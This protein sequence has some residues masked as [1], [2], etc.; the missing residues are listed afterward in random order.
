MK[1]GNIGIR[2]LADIGIADIDV[3]GTNRRKKNVFDF[4]GTVHF[5]RSKP[6]TK[7]K[8]GS[9][10]PDYS[11][12]F[13]FDLYNIEH[14]PKGS[15]IYYLDQE[16]KFIK[17]KEY[18]GYVSSYLNIWPPK[19]DKEKSNV[20][21][22]VK[23]SDGSKV[24]ELLEYECKEWNKD[25]KTF[26]IP[27]TKIEI[28]KMNTENSD[29][30]NYYKINIQC[31]E[32]FENDIS[33]NTKYNENIVGRIIVKANAKIYETTIQPVLVSF[34][35]TASTSIEIKDHETFV[36]GLVNYFN[37]KSFN[38]AY[39]RGKLADK[40]HAVTF[41][42]S[43]FLK[44]DVVKL[45]NKNLFVNYTESNQIN[46]Q[47]YNNLIQQRYASIYYNI[48][49]NQANIEKMENC[50][51]L[52]IKEFKSDFNYGTVSN[53][54]KAKQFHENHVATNAWNKI[55]DTLYK[56]YLQYKA[57]YLKNQ[58]VNLNQDNIIYVF[59]NSSVEGGKNE[60]SKAQAYSVRESG[61]THIFNSALK[62]TENYSL[63]VHE[64][65]HAFG[66]FHTFTDEANFLI[67]GKNQLQSQ[68][69]AE[70]QK[71][72][73]LNS[74]KSE[75]AKYITIDAK[76]TTIYRVIDDSK[77][78]R[79]D[80]REFETKFLVNI[81]GESSYISESSELIKDTKTS[82]IELEKNP[83]P[84]FDLVS[85]KSKIE[86]R[87]NDFQ[88]QIKDLTP[89]IGITREQSETLENIMDYRQ[90]A[91][92]Q[93]DSSVEEGKPNFNKGFKYKSF[94]QWQWKKMIN[95]SVENNYIRHIS[96]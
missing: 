71:I 66:L 41:L 92:P 82:V 47:V 60:I 73:N 86:K 54:K 79:I 62:D 6:Q 90:Y 74:A 94:Y 8:I 93:E 37:N 26:S 29:G 16:G 59:I 32:S 69:D 18:T 56:D 49:K 1:T 10:D 70:K 57:E 27:S 14:C 7:G 58:A 43:D 15:V 42:K 81:V 96:K 19:V 80:I 2:N 72:S 84:A 85:V 63:I 68:V 51:K 35:D 88:K 45:K 39:I 24:P 4:K 30:N 11:G 44:D 9:D 78:S 64:M 22:Y 87:I 40:T 77:T 65:G 5:Y 52:I 34:G 20:I 76:Y 91:S 75:D 53:L 17:D 67:N 46:A 61:K 38:Q 83:L 31:I 3:Y 13:G 55:K 89:F 12:Q 36:I 50:I 95:I 21:L 23:A 33:I 48:S 28:T 25:S